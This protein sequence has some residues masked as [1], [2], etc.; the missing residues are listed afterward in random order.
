MSEIRMTLGGNV[1]R[2]RKR[3]GYTME[4]LSDMAGI[5]V[6]FLGYI[7]LGTKAPSLSTL[8]RLARSLEVSAASLVGGVR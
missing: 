8:V 7:E 3:R 4:D 5:H 2:L 6:T 1:R